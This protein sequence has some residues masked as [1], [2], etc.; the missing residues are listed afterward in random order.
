MDKHLEDQL[1]MIKKEIPQ[2]N[3]N[4]KSKI[5]NQA[6]SSSKMNVSKC[7]RSFFTNTFKIALA[8]VIIVFTL[9]IGLIINN[10]NIDGNSSQI[11][12]SNSQP[13]DKD[14]NGNSGG[15]ESSIK[16]SYVNKNMTLECAQA[17]F[18]E[19]YD[20][21]T[22]CI[23]NKK[24]TAYL[25]LFDN[26]NLLIDVKLNNGEAEIK[27]SASSEAYYS[28]SIENSNTKYHY[29]DL[30]Y[31]RGTY[32]NNEIKANFQLSY[33]LSQ[34]ADKYKYELS[35]KNIIMQRSSN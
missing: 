20:I 4:L 26:D 5:Y 10:F 27:K 24:N 33:S 12:P 31:P 34:T 9:L 3:P 35:I 1:E 22:V 25:Y 15:S 28:I 21:I 6:V 14:P 17:I 13:L 11:P 16:P 8:S 30:Y 18:T 2:I 19:E 23:K 7:N 29:V 32:A